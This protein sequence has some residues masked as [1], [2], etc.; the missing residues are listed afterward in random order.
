MSSNAEERVEAMGE[1][2]HGFSLRDVCWGYRDTFAKTIEG[3]FEEG[4]LG[5][6]REEASRHFFDLLKNADQS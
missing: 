2:L 6:E 3:L 5:A 4:V 1:R